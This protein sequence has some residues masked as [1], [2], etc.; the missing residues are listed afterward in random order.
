MATEEITTPPK[1]KFCLLDP[2][3][4]TKRRNAEHEGGIKEAEQKDSGGDDGKVA[5]TR[6]ERKADRLVGGGEEEATKGVETSED[7]QESK[8]KLEEENDY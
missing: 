7:E 8:S 4:R 1:N 3:G 2:L 5:A 6:V